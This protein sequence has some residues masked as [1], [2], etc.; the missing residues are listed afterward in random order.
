MLAFRT[1]AVTSVAVLT[2]AVTGT[3]FAT[4][5]SSH[6]DANLSSHDVTTTTTSTP[7]TTTTGLPIVTLLAPTNSS[8]TDDVN[9]E[10]QAD[11]SQTDVTDSQTDVNDSQTDVSDSQTDVTDS[12]TDVN[13][14]QS[15]V[16]NDQSDSTDTSGA[17]TSG[18]VLSGSE[19]DQG[20]QLDGSVNLN[21]GD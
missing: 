12:Q 5:G 4:S 10:S 3:A 16:N 1:A 7:T 14:S 13:D 8:V 20:I 9:D 21:S 11:E 15:A 17:L 2:L 18:S 19:G 6:V